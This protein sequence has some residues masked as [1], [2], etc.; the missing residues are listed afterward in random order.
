M[1]K[2]TPTEVKVLS[3]LSRASD[4]S[5]GVALRTKG[6]RAQAFKLEERGMLSIPDPWQKPLIARL[7]PAGQ[8]ELARLRVMYNRAWDE[9]H[10]V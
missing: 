5:S 8:A 9:A 2:L 6:D 10:H 1:N 3:L 7:T 4:V